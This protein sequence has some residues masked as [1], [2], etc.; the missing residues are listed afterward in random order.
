MI[1]ATEAQALSDRNNEYRTIKSV[2]WAESELSYIEDRIR[3]AIEKGEYVTDYW[4][5]QEL[6][7][8]NGLTQRDAKEGL[9]IVLTKLGYHTAYWLNCGEDKVFK[10]YINWERE[11]N[12]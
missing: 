6:L 3:R 9:E 1:T 5:S 8:E 2:E 10:I 4:W 12:E 7:A 11:Q